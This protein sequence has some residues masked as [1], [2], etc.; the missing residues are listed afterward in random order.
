MLEGVSTF[1]GT[2]G[3]GSVGVGVGIEEGETEEEEEEEG[4]EEEGRTTFCRTS[5]STTRLMRFFINMLSGASARKFESVQ[6]VASFS[7]PASGVCCPN[8]RTDAGA[9]FSLSSVSF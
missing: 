7:T 3:G 5:S 2:D 9:S 8:P 1:L 4:E 6:L